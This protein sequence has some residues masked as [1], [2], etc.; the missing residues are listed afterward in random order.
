MLMFFYPS[1]LLRFLWCLV[2]T[3]SSATFLS[4]IPHLCRCVDPVVIRHH[5]AFHLGVH[6]LP[7]NLF[8]GIQNEKGTK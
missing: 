4:L 6:C 3:V 1:V 7:K 8:A 5:A 2:E